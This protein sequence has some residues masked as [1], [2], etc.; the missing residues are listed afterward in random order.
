MRRDIFDYLKKLESNDLRKIKKYLISPYFEIK[1]KKR[2]TALFEL[3]KQGH[4]KYEK[5]S[6]D[7]LSKKLAIS[8]NSVR[9]LK[10]TLIDCIEHYLEL[11]VLDEQKQLKIQ[12]MAQ[13]YDDLNM[14][15]YFIRYADLQLEKLEKKTC[16][17]Q[18]DYQLKYEL[19]SKKYGII[20]H[21]MIDINNTALGEAT[22]TLSHYYLY[23]CLKNLNGLKS[24]NRMIDRETE[25]PL[26]QIMIN[27]INTVKLIED[28]NLK[29][30]YLTY[31]YYNLIDDEIEE[32]ENIYETLKSLI[33]EDWEKLTD[34]YKYETYQHMSNMANE[35]SL[36]S[37][38]LNKYK[39]ECFLT[40]RF[41]IEKKVHQS[42]QEMHHHLFLGIIFSAC[43]AQKFDWCK[44][45][46]SEHKKMIPLIEKAATL[47]LSLAYYDFSEHHIEDAISKLY[48]IQPLGVFF[49][50]LVKT[51]MLKCLFILK[52]DDRFFNY[53]NSSYNYIKNHTELNEKT[54][55]IYLTFIL[56]LKKVYRARTIKDFKKLNNIKETMRNNITI[57]SSKWLLKIIN[58]L[59]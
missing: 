51:L 24:T 46:I 21:N 5:T 53:Y 44:K 34:D 50:L 49:N 54:K 47:K 14:H 56:N 58:D 35:I 55:L 9:N 41:W 15:Q 25:I 43:D 36:Q 33:W 6:D 7:F 42:H 22:N 23:E 12:L 27:S 39:N 29:V 19:L 52:H 40:H 32:K 48:A 11:K 18:A 1:S 45:F 17:N 2:V 13:A 16:L 30:S 37:T 4:P 57:S 20:A 59:T 31:K 26:T 10:T 8:I 3:L 28:F 38:K